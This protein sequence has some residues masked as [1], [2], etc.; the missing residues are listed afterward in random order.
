LP[1][2]AGSSADR[3]QDAPPHKRDANSKRI[4]VGKVQITAYVPRDVAE[5][6]RDAVVATTPYRNG[7]RG[8]SELVTDAVAEKIERLQRQFNSARPFPPRQVNLRPGR[9]MS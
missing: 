7:Y 4:A 5:A 8:L 6:A 3:N 9:R 2:G 1:D